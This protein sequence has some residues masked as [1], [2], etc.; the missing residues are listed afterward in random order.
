MLCRYS[1]DGDRQLA[2]VTRSSS[3]IWSSRDL[4]QNSGD[5]HLAVSEEGRIL[6]IWADS[7][8][9][10]FWT[11]ERINGTWSTLKLAF[12]NREY[13]STIQGLFFAGNNAVCLTTGEGLGMLEETSGTWQPTDTSAWSASRLDGASAIVKN[14]ILYVIAVDELPN[15]AVWGT[16]NGFS[17]HLEEAYVDCFNNIGMASHPSI[18]VSNDLAGVLLQVGDLVFFGSRSNNTWIIERIA[19]Q[20]YFA[21]ENQALAIDRNGSVYVCMLDWSEEHRLVFGSRKP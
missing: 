19:E 15:K 8:G 2:A 16:F 11:S 20:G 21:F 1:N 12:D 9:D 10:Y 6:A 5:A 7:E 18:G 17:W 4:A 14:G 3:G 13:R